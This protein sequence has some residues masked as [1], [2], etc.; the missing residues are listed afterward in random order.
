M[1]TALLV[2]DMQMEMTHRTEAGRDRANP[3]AERHIA[4]LLSLFRS[5]G[6]PVI[7]VHHDEPGTPVAFGQPGGEVMPCAAPVPGETVLVKSR[8]SAFSGTWLDAHLGENGIDRLVLVGA[9][10]GFCITSTTRAA[11]DLGHA[12]IL[13][14]NALIGFDVPR[15]DGSRI[16]AAQVLDVTLALLGS[17]FARVVRSEDVATML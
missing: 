3:D 10:A 15:G 16:P 11:S 6:L 7:H 1:T 8:S 14:G 5:R 17:D 2:I 13:P 4:D 12:V 9:V